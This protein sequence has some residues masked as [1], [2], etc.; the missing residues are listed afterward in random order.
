MNRLYNIPLYQENVI[1]AINR[2]QNFSFLYG[3]NVLITG[4]TGLIGSFITDM[5]CFCNKINQDEK[6]KIHIYAC[7]RSE[8][9]L[10]KRFDGVWGEGYL[11]FVVQDFTQPVMFDCPADIVIHA[12]SNAY[13]A[14]Y[15][16]DPVGTILVNV[17]GTYGLL[18]F[19][20]R[21]RAERFLFVSS[22]EVYGDGGG[23]VDEYAENF[24]GYI[25]PINPRSCYPSSKR[26]AETLCVSYQKQYGLET[27]IARPGNIYGP[28]VT[29]SDNRA[30]VQFLNNAVNHE[31]IVLKSM[32]NQLRSYCY[33]ADCASGILTV[34]TTG[35]SGQAYNIANPNSRIT[36]AEFASMTADLADVKVVFCEP[37]LEARQE[38]SP[39]SRAVLASEKLEALGWQGGFDASTG[40]RDVFS[41]MEQMKQ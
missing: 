33:V 16:R 17:L 4:A 5:L 40:I 23:I 28:N 41:I 39:I 24:S 6:K 31:D 32:G 36:I 19:A 18:E 21:K 8:E 25:D 35:D 30:A 22:G 15:H 37:D 26:T 10:Q 12:A 3:K 34:L 9:N 13:P 20:R 2:T 1:E 29:A 27:V 11:H 38:R 7:S 14:A